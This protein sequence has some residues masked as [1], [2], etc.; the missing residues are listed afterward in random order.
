MTARPSS[1]SYSEAGGWCKVHV[2]DKDHHTHNAQLNKAMQLL[3]T[4]KI[5]VCGSENK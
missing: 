3:L 1:K 5:R 2:V 4:R